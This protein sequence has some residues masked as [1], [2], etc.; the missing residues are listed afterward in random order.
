MLHL[1][2]VV[3]H[4]SRLSHLSRQQRPDCGSSTQ[5]CAI[6][7]APSLPSS[8]PSVRLINYLIH[9]CRPMP[10]LC[11][12]CCPMSYLLHISSRLCRQ[13]C[14]S[15]PSRVSRL[16]P[17]LSPGRLSPGRLSPGRLS[18]GRLSPGRLS[19]DR[20]SSDQP[21]TDRSV[22]DSLA[23][24]ADG[25]TDGADGPF[26][27]AAACHAHCLSG[28]R[29]TPPPCRPGYRPFTPHAHAHRLLPFRARAFALPP[30]VGH[31]NKHRSPPVK[32]GR[33]HPVHIHVLPRY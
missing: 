4:L 18:P 24:Q 2:R 13:Q 21:V 3:S 10:C 23:R 6:N 27:P 20:L 32:S 22:G 5:Q 14:P 29:S 9:L 19:S 1:S 25:R 17:R 15:V 7:I 16:V 8:V 26:A 30:E 12:L 33:K 11:R 31:V 28:D